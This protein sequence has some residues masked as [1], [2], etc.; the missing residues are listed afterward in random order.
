MASEPLPTRFS[1][2][3]YVRTDD[4]D[5]VRIPAASGMGSTDRQRWARVSPPRLES[6][7][8]PKYWVRVLNQDPVTDEWLLLGF[9]LHCG[10]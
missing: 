10:V 5:F 4:A 1:V 7:G 2:W 3:H 9:G 6:A 8:T